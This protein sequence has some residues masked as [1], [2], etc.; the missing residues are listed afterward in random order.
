MPESSIMLETC[1]IGIE[2]IFIFF[3]YIY[4]NT[5]SSLEEYLHYPDQ[6]LV[7]RRSYWK[8]WAQ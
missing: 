6:L 5:F 7:I 3:V 1:V 4:K 8:E 2:F